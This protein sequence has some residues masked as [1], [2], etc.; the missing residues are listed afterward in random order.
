VPSFLNF[1]WLLSPTAVKNASGMPYYPTP[2][3]PSMLMCPMNV[4]C[5][6]SQG[7]VR[8]GQVR[9]GQVKSGQVR[10]GRVG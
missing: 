1:V 10:K 5:K 3:E 8:S 9:S 2:H 6:V 7:Q 4:R